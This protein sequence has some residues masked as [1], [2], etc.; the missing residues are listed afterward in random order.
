MAN[1]SGGNFIQLIVTTDSESNQGITSADSIQR[2]VDEAMEGS[3]DGTS[4]ISGAAGG[5]A[6]NRVGDLLAKGK[7]Y[8]AKRLLKQA[9]NM[10]VGDPYDPDDPSSIAKKKAL[11]KAADAFAAYT[12]AK[13]VFSNRQLQIGLLGLGAG[14]ILTAK[15]HA[16]QIYTKYAN[17]ASR[18]G[19]SNIA[20]TY[21]NTI[22]AGM[23]IA[24][25]VAQVGAGIGLGV[26]AGNGV[27]KLIGGNKGLEVGSAVGMVIAVAS[28]ALTIANK[29]ME[30]T[31]KKSDLM[32]E[33]QTQM[34]E[35]IQR[36]NR[37]G[38]ITA[39]RGRTSFTKYQ[40]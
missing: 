24:G 6:Q 13:T 10:P 29:A 22:S 37:L 39:G 20:N 15:N 34:A 38:Q 19:M 5:F 17:Y 25:S 35:S 11:D 4:F 27:A 28:T 18:S 8:K 14:A 26:T 31:Q 9:S 21:Q 33:L 1:T 3:S 30:Y 40:M 32:W 16:Q 7:E 36:I 2:T 23:D 12:S